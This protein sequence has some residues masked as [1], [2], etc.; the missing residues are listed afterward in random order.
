M[1]PLIAKGYFAVFP[2]V[3]NLLYLTTRAIDARHGGRFV[4]TDIEPGKVAVARRNLD[5]TG[6]TAFSEVREGDALQT[7][8][9]LAA[10]S[11]VTT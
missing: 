10:P 8:K 4:G 11:G 5:E 3:G 6:L 7:L 9:D 2:A 1:K